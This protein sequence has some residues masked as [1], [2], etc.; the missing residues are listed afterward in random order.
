MANHKS[1]IKRHRQSLKRR[2]ANRSARS[3]IRTAIKNAREAAV[4]GDK[5]K[6]SELMR[7]AQKAIARA[8]AKGLYHQRNARRK[9]SRLASAVAKTAAKPEGTKA[10]AAKATKAKTATKSA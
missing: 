10:P 6:A 8:S 5:T 9:I 3:S 4:S 2:D 7:V 1:A